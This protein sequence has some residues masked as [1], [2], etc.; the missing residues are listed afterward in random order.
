MSILELGKLNKN[1]ANEDNR[2]LKNTMNKL[3]EAS[4]EHLIVISWL[5][6]RVKDLKDENPKIK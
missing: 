1:F 6:K 5:F 3:I 2:R 4:Q